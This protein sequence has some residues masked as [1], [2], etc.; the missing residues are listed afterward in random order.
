METWSRVIYRKLKVGVLEGKLGPPCSKVRSH[1]I[2]SLFPFNCHK[3]IK[4]F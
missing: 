4:E 2:F 1:V 3:K